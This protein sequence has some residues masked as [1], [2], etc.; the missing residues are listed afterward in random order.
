MATFTDEQVRTII[1][2]HKRHF[3]L[4]LSFVDP[5]PAM[6]VWIDLDHSWHEWYDI[7]D[8]A[9]APS[10]DAAHAADTQTK[11]FHS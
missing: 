11:D 10:D 6:M 9:G 1:S 5:S 8:V 2:Q 4:E 7:I 3:T